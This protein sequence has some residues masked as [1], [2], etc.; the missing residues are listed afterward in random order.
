M[1]L[2]KKKC[3][4]CIVAFSVLFFAILFSIPNLM[5]NKKT[6]PVYAHE[7]I[8]ESEEIKTAEVSPNMLKTDWAS[9][10]NLGIRPSAVTYLKFKSPSSSA[11]TNEIDISAYGTGIYPYVDG[12]TLYN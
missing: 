2:N 5:Q 1:N 6:Q 12:T 3:L 10:D 7:E 11:T 4:S 8:V 9:S